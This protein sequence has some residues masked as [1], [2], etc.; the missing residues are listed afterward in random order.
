MKIPRTAL[1]L[2]V[3]ALAT[4]GCVPTAPIAAGIPSPTATAPTPTPTVIPTP[5]PTV[6]PPTKPALADLRLT[7]DGLGPLV[8]G[9]VP[10]VTDP[11][12]DIL[13]FDPE[14]CDGQFGDRGLWV[15]NYP[16]T[17]AFF[18][19]TD[20]DGRLTRILPGRSPIPLISDTGIQKG[21][22][23]AELEAAYPAGFDY[24]IPNPQLADVY[25]IDG[26]YGRLV[27]EVAP[28]ATGLET[29]VLMRSTE[30]SDSPPGS[31]WKTD[32]LG[33]GCPTGQ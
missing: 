9:Q 21:S 1:L 15:P 7:A 17:D 26:T 20:R 31:R 25:A 3:V 18:V 13:V 19:S 32:G 8:I 16:E 28:D 5:L 6:V 23:R 11:A 4:A 22:S 29:V 24:E 12:L 14:F 10:P 30:L 2:V 27:F 33:G